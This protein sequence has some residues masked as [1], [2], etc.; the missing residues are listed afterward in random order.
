ML[1]FLW[2]LMGGDDVAELGAAEGREE[3]SKKTMGRDSD[4]CNLARASWYADSMRDCETVLVVVR[5]RLG[6]AEETPAQG[7]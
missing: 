4:E 2:R 6:H 3:D 5:W 7:V 1:C